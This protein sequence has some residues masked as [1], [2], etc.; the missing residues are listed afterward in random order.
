MRWRSDSSQVPS[1]GSRCAKKFFE[2][3]IATIRQTTSNHWWSPLVLAAVC[4]NL[5]GPIRAFDVYWNIPTFMC[6]QYQMNFS[7]IGP[8]Y[9]VSQN[10]NDTFRG[11][12]ISILYDPGKFP[13]LL[14]KSSTKVLY[15]RNG[16]VPQ[17]GNLTEHLDVFRKHMDELVTDQNFSGVGIIDFE[18]WRPIFRQNFGSLQPYKDLSMKIEKQRHPNLP[19]KWLEA[20]A[21][22]RFESTGREFMARTLLLA[23][24]MRPR[25]A[26]GYYAFPYCF[27]MNGGSSGNGQRED[28]SADVQRENDRIQWLFD[29]SDIIFPSVYLREKLGAGDRV[30]LIR[31]RVKEAIRVARRA[32]AQPKPRVLTYIRYVYTDSIKYLT[33][34]DWIN[35][36]NAM[37]QFGSD[38]VILWGSSYDLNN[39][40]KCLNFKSYMDTT[41]GPILQSLRQRYV[42]EAPK[43]MDFPLLQWT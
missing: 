20:E 5:T 28:C 23:K 17:E 1:D 40:E 18:S 26:W 2:C 31:G 42:V 36:F 22:R 34:P 41:L 10:G 15:K 29:G 9:G 8:T 24:Q 13:A 32:N 30:K 19:P 25:A 6:Q 35:A 12:A 43:T 11:S 39:K 33:E 21:T 7:S 16:G 14:E 37:K 27:N 38:G 4:I 3:R